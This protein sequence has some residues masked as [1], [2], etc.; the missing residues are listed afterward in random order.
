MTMDTQGED[1]ARP[2][3]QKVHASSGVQ[4]NQVDVRIIA[5][6]NVDLKLLVKEGNSA[7]ISII[8]SMSSPLIFPLCGSVKKTFLR[9]GLFLQRYSEE[10]GRP[11]RRISP[12]ALRPLMAYYMAGQCS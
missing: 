4:G 5:A 3:G 12:E 11:M 9:C 7:T 2:P 8:G 6:T 10:N 1:S